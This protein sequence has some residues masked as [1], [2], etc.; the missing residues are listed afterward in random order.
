M[1]LKPRFLYFAA[2]NAIGS[3]ITMLAII[4]NPALLK[5]L[6]AAGLPLGS[7]AA[8]PLLGDAVRAAD[9]PQIS[10]IDLKTQLDRSPDTLVLLD[11]RTKAEFDTDH[12]PGAI[13]I[14]VTEIESGNRLETVRQAIGSKKLIVYC[15]S[16]QRSH[17]AI[18]KLKTAQITGT[19][20]TGGVVEWKKQIDPALKILAR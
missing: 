18:A 13:H 9:A 7:L 16:G 11:V 6:I 20:L 10:P 2:F 4:L 8:V 3:T 15:H 14:P 5:P 19:N 17:R 1:K 12:L